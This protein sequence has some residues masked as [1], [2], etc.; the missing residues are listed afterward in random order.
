[1]TT[2]LLI[3]AYLFVGFVVS[4][5]P[6][7]HIAWMRLDVPPIWFWPLWPILLPGCLLIVAGMSINDWLEG[8]IS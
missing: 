1:M 6:A 7:A 2:F 4:V 3:L 8:I 5:S